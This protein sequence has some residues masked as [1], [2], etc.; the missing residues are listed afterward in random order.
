MGNFIT[1]ISFAVSLLFLLPFVCNSSAEPL[2]LFGGGK[3][4]N[5]S[6]QI[7]IDETLKTP[8]GTIRIRD[9]SSR[10]MIWGKIISCRAETPS[11][12]VF[13]GVCQSKNSSL[14]FEGVL[15]DLGDGKDNQRDYFSIAISNG[16]SLSGKFN[17]GNVKLKR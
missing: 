11:K 6:I 10:K 3:V 4:H 17:K 15:D 8:I 1:K 12:I 2:R 16:Y 7:N 13:Q 5:A 9:R 14:T